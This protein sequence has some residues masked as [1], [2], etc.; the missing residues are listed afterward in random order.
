[1]S[2]QW[3]YE[4]LPGLDILA[5]AGRLDARSAERFAGA[6]AWPLRRGTGPVIL[7]LS[8]L[9]S[10]DGAGRNAIAS[11]ARRL[12][13]CARTLELAA[14]PPDL[15]RAVAGD[16]R[17]PVITH[18]DLATALRAHGT[19]SPNPSSRVWRTTGWPTAEPAAP[20]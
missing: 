8:V 19:H 11:A 7:D 13:T 17:A 4:L 16:P 18:P 10:F 9:E 1:M 5:L 6:L 20:S 3:R 14:A 2:L 15:A 12:A